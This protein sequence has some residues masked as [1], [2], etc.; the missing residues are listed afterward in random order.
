MG[1]IVF[2]KH[3]AT[4]NEPL[5]VMVIGDP[6]VDPGE[7][8]EARSRW[9]AAA[10]F[11]CRQRPD[12]I[13]WI[14]DHWGLESINQDSK[15]RGGK[16]RG[17]RA[18]KRSFLQDIEAGREAIDAFEG[19]I[20][21]YNTR[22]SR[23]G[24]RELVYDPRRVFCLGNHEMFVDR[25]GSALE[26]YVDM[27]S[28]EKWISEWLRAR[29]FHVVPF[30]T[31]YGINGVD[32]VHY[33]KHGAKGA[34]VQIAHA[35]RLIGRSTVWG[36]THIFGYAEREIRRVGRESEW[37]KWLCLPTFK[38]PARLEVGQ[39]SGIV[40]LDDVLNGNFTHSI[41]ST[42]RLLRDYGTFCQPRA[43]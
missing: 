5:R 7:S 2:G 33:V 10:R 41:V 20:K 15:G 16:G 8:L 35:L 27:L 26:E 38:D 31:P 25:A 11:A 18:P 40:L 21:R 36:H 12:V 23:S 4:S 32:F 28:T 19:E 17:A 39:Q 29:K 30:L 34:V 43:A 14:G 22:A 42:D 1:P 24:K 37:D 9:V 13:V 6:H 3:A